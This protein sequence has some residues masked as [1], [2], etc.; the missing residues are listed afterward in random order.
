M[1]A[2]CSSSDRVEPS[3]QSQT[4]LNLSKGSYDP[5]SEG[6]SK[7]R[8][9]TDICF[10][11]L[12]TV[13]SI[14]LLGLVA[15]CAL[16]GDIDRVIKGYDD[17]GYICGKENKQTS[18]VCRHTDLRDK[19]F[20]VIRLGPEKTCEQVCPNSTYRVFLL[21]RCIPIKQEK[22]TSRLGVADFLQEVTEDLE[23]CKMELLYLFLIA[24]GFSIVILILFRYLVGVMV[25]IVLIA[26]TLVSLG[27]TLY[28]WFIW[29]QAKDG[30]AH[31]KNDKDAEGRSVTAYLV[32]AILA[33]IAT[34]IIC[35]II[36][37]M[38]KRI[39]LVIQLFREAGK[40]VASMPMLLFE[41][42]I[43]FVMLGLVVAAWIY[44]CL[45]IESS[46]DLKE[47]EN[48]KMYY[49][50]DV[51]M[52]V[53]RW[54]NLFAVLWFAQF[55][56]GCQHMVIAGAV[57]TWFFTRNKQNLGTPIIR[58]FCN[59]VRYHLGSVAL[60]SLLIAIIQ[61]I[62]IV[63]KFIQSKV[64][65]H[66]NAITTCIFRT[67]QCCLYC[68]EKILQF[69]TRN[70]YIEI[71]I[72][73]HSFCKAGKQ[74]FKLLAS[75]A[76]RVAAI[77]SVGDFVL[78]LGKAMVVIATV[79]CGVQMLKHKDGIMHLWVPLSLAGVFAYLVAHCFITVYEMAI[80]TIFICFCEDCELNDGINRPYFMSRGLMEFVQNS[81]KALALLNEKHRQSPQGEAWSTSPIRTPN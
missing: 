72:H 12:F 68:F 52:K 74:A 23:L 8:H 36:L 5:E 45:L 24:F 34:V 20:L 25:W 79:V 9:C 27:G 14:G 56:T 42:L 33:T 60:G 66:N 11:L 18:S 61:M 4:Q 64:K 28:L 21:N 26:V 65:N 57:A 1:G 70:A 3:S 40:A 37:V 46:G 48:N 6:I 16:H 62:R 50:K 73:G 80:D 17:C 77:N 67:C 78:F 35:L 69:L 81:K 51:I 29:K 63:L 71:A 32:Y 43:T 38:R 49:K 31:T 53:T 58:S 41:P 47:G 7:N 22:L 59:L 39:K 30:L 10:L 15:Y 75:N 13:F 76:L 2:C 55:C 19:K 54:Y 44:F